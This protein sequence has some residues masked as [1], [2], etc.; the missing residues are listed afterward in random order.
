LGYKAFIKKEAPF[1]SFKSAELTDYSCRISRNF[2]LAGLLL[3]IPMVLGHRYQ[4]EVDKEGYYDRAYR[5]RYNEHQ[6]NI[7]RGSLLMGALYGA[8]FTISKKSFLLGFPKGLCWGTILAATYNNF[9][10]AKRIK[11][12]SVIESMTE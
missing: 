7:D 11:Q 12:Q 6:L 5:I 10:Q 4:N 3:S 8:M 2:M 9:Q 1:A